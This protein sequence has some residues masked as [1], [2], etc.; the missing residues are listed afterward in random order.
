MNLCAAL[1][2]LSIVFLVG[3][4]RGSKSKQACQA[5]GFVLEYIILAVFSWSAIEGFH[6]VRSLV[7]PMKTEIR[8]FLKKALPIGWG[9]H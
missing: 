2:I 7:F 8:G 3:A 1:I 5:I 6:S 4:D 9:E